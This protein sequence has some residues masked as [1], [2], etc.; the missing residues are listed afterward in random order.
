MFHSPLFRSGTILSSDGFEVKLRSRYV[1]EYRD[2]EVFVEIAYDAVKPDLD[3]LTKSLS[4][5]SSD[6]RQITL[7]PD[8]CSRILNGICAALTWK[9]FNVNLVASA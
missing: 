5:Y 4:A 6:N 7:T 1:L 3:L 2:K 8:T 9:G